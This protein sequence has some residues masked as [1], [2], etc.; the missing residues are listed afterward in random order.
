MFRRD[1]SSMSQYQVSRKATDE[2]PPER[3][4]SDSRSAL[5]EIR[6]PLMKPDASFPFLKEQAT[7]S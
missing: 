6:H 1:R 4:V 2:L 3:Q 7:G 5:P